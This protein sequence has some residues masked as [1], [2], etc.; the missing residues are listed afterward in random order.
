MITQNTWAWIVR[1]AWLP[2]AGR[3]AAAVGIIVAA[4][5]LARVASMGL[6]R[7]RSRAGAEAA[8]IYIVEKLA[9]YGLVLAGSFLALSALGV[10]LTSLTVFVGAIGVGGSGMDEEC[11]NY[12]L[13]QVLGPQPP[14]T[15]NI[16]ARPP[17]MGDPPQR[18]RGPAPQ[19]QPPTR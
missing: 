14:L 7:L 12:A 10:D 19:Q 16:P 6:Q 11:A 9:G 2:L 3:L 5:A 1:G 15:P 4:V 13:T 18:G 17:L 8:S